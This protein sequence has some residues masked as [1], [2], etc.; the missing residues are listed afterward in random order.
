MKW[1]VR[2]QHNALVTIFCDLQLRLKPN[3]LLLPEAPVARQE[4][5]LHPLQVK[6]PVARFVSKVVRVISLQIL[7]RLR[8]VLTCWILTENY[9]RR[10]VGGEGRGSAS[11]FLALRACF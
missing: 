9:T 8:V 11:V 7:K 4:P 5:F 1:P 2:E 3:G 6:G 10:S